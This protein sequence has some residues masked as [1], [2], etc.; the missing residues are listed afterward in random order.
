MSN[1]LGLNQVQLQ[2]SSNEPVHMTQ[3]FKERPTKCL[4]NA[5]L[6]LCQSYGGNITEA[7]FFTKKA[8]KTG[9]LKRIFKTKKLYSFN[10]RLIANFLS[11]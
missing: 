1:W 4:V 5:M 2:N 8:S 9:E 11:G 6:L 3:T 10:F 7:V